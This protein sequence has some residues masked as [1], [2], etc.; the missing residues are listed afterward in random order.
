MIHLSNNTFKKINISVRVILTAFWID[1]LVSKETGLPRRWGGE[2][3]K[4][5]LVWNKL[6]KHE[7]SVSLD[8]RLCLKCQFCYIFMEEILPLSTCLKPYDIFAC[9]ISTWYLI[10]KLLGDCFPHQ[11]NNSWLFLSN[12]PNTIAGSHNVKV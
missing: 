5:N 3:L 1:E 6:T 10:S 9:C 12:L 2:T 7:M 4:F 8:I 11:T